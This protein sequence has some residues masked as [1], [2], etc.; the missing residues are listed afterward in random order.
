VFNNYNNAVTG[1][2]NR[3][4]VLLAKSTDGGQTFGAPL[5]VADFY[6]L[7]DCATY[8]GGQDAGRACVPEK[9]PTNNSIFRA[10]NYPSGAV[11][12]TNA[13]RVVV[14]FGSYIN[15][16]S[17][18]TNGCTPAGLSPITGQDLYTGVKAPGGCNNDIL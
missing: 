13:A 3:N 2:D 14:T 7:P 11:D 1:T 9:G 15:V 12:P 8:Q 18:E 5:K 4:Q 16:H 17:N 6:D 10:N